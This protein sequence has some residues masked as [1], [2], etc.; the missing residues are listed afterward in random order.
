MNSDRAAILK[1]ICARLTAGD[2]G[3][4]ASLL[5]RDY[6][7][8]P[9]AAVERKY[10][11]AEAIRIF[12]RDGF[13]DRYSGDRLIFPGA[14]RLLSLRLPEDFPF[15]P[16]WKMTVTHEAYWELS[17]TV[18]HVVPVSRGG[19]DSET[20][21]VTTSMRRN[22]A[23]SNWTLEQLGWT[24]LPPGS[25]EDWDGLMGWFLDEMKSDPSL[26]DNSHLH[27]WHAAAV[28]ATMS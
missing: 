24:L 6:P 14:L 11:P 5:R 15:H 23:K 28:R 25:I 17:P 20:N 4:A 13:L 22:S 1:E 2:P 8:E 19:A 7:F 3:S 18:D 27:R 21:W 16:N 12:A 10:G 26:L 9:I